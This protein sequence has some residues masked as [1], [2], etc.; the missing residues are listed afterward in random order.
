MIRWSS[1]RP[2][3]SREFVIRATRVNPSAPSI[4]AYGQEIQCP[5]W[6]A[7]ILSLRSLSRWGG[8]ANV[9]VFHA[10]GRIFRV[11]AAKVFVFALG[12]LAARLHTPKH[13]VVVWL[14]CFAG[15]TKR[16]ETKFLFSR[17][18]PNTQNSQ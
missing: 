13:F 16:T 2:S 1:E 4:S 10:T 8:A 3:A 7:A 15:R 18:A 5:P 9:Q 12:D 17:A 6:P 14:R 11:V